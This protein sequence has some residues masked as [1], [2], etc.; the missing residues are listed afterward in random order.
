[1]AKK[2]QIKVSSKRGRSRAGRKWRRQAKENLEKLIKI[3]PN[4]P[5][6]A[7]AIRLSNP[8]TDGWTT[9]CKK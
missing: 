6:V 5:L 2:H 1:M 7:L 3:E 8:R 9:W 4:H